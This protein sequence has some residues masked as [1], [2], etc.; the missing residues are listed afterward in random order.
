MVVVVVG[1]D[2]DVAV[3]VVAGAITFNT[4]SYTD[5]SIV[6]VYT[7]KSFQINNIVSAYI[8]RHTLFEIHTFLRFFS[9]WLNRD[10]TFY[11][12]P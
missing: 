1:S 5:L 9:F 4:C 8:R 11:L 12:S 2:E 7:S 3:Y 10:H 6:F